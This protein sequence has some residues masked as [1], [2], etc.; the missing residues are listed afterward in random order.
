MWRTP[1]ESQVPNTHSAKNCFGRRSRRWKSN[2][3]VRVH[4]GALVTNR[5]GPFAA[6]RDSRNPA[7][8]RPPDRSSSIAPA[9]ARTYLKVIGAIDNT[10]DSACG[11]S[12]MQGGM[13][14][15]RSTSRFELVRQA[16]SP[17]GTRPRRRETRRRRNPKRLRRRRRRPGLGADALLDSPCE[18]WRPTPLNVSASESFENQGC[19]DRRGG[20]GPLRSIGGIDGAGVLRVRPHILPRAV[21][22]QAV[23]GPRSERR[24]I[25]D[26]RGAMVGR[27]D[28]VGLFLTTGAFTTDASTRG[29][30]RRSARDRPHRRL[31]SLRPPQGPSNSA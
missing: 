26:F 30:A 21:P 18:A 12:P 24:T 20:D 11:P 22:V 9:W 6:R 8:G 23:C 2:G 17:T 19:D 4:S 1:D 31:R 15:A 27:A 29:R 7:Q 25:R 3:G 16:L 5:D 10:V 28:I 13:S 14:G